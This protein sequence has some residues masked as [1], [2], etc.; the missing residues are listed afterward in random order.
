M[1]EAFSPRAL[2]FDAY[3]TLF[4]VFSVGAACEDRFP[5]KGAELSRLWRTKQLEYSWLRSLMGRYTAFEAITLDALRFSCRALGVELTQDD[6]RALLGAY[7][8]LELFPEVTRS[9]EALG[10]CRKAI[11]SN[12]SPAMLAA[13]VEHAGISRHFDAVI[14][15]DAL[16]MYKPSPEVYELATH[17]LG[18][19]RDETGFVSSNFWDITGAASFGFRTFWINRSN[20]PRDEL[21]FQPYRVI[22]GLDELA[23]ELA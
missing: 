3:G 15:V 14:S 10:D 2:V 4:D 11:L 18:I 20:A 12:G 17:K 8:R 13:V 6:A 19:A 16:Q 9:L 7:R 5:G 23:A 22:R 21:G 1:P